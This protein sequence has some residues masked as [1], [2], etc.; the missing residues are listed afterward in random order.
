MPAQ[1]SSG[2]AMASGDDSKPANRGWNPEDSITLLL[3]IMQ[4]NNQQLSVAGWKSIKD[5]AQK[6]FDGKY[7]EQGAK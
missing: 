1:P 7:G 4:E 3:I 6:V 2:A 5:R